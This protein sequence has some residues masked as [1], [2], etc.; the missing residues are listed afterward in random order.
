MIYAS[1]AKIGSSTKIKYNAGMF[2]FELYHKTTG[3]S[4]K[5][6]RIMTIVSHSSVFLIFILSGAE[7]TANSKRWGMQKATR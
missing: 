5:M 7:D 6:E 3:Q 4:V 2:C 1:T